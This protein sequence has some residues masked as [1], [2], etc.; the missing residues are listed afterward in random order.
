MENIYAKLPP[1]LL[2][3]VT[4]FRLGLSLVDRDGALE[5]VTQLRNRVARDGQFSKLQVFYMPVT[6]IPPAAWFYDCADCYFYLE[7]TRRCELVDGNIEPY[8]WCGLWLNRREDQPFSWL[9][10]AVT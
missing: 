1:Q 2:A 7:G 4:P 10:R 3:I 9:E 8:A 6:L 5:M